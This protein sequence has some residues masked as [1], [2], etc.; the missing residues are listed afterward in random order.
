MKR[1]IKNIVEAYQ[2]LLWLNRILGL[3]VFEVPIGRVWFF[4]SIFY[5]LIRSLAYGF[6]L[7]YAFLLIPPMPLSY[8]SV[9]L[10][11][12]IIV[13]IN[14]VIASVT[15]ILGIYNHKKTK[16]FFKNVSMIDATLECFEIEPV[17]YDDLKENL[18]LVLAWLTGVIIIFT[19][20]LILIYAIF[21]H[22]GHALAV[23]VAFEIPLQINSMI[24]VNFIV[25]IRTIGRR[26]EKLN[27]LIK[28]ITT[29]PSQNDLQHV[30][31]LDLLSPKKTKKN[32]NKIS[33]RSSSYIKNKYDVE[34]ILKMSRQLH[35]NLCTTSREVN[36][37][38]SKQISMQIASS[39]FILTGFGYCIYLVYH[40]PN[41]SL[42][43]KIQLFCSLGAWIVV[44]V[45]RM[46]QVVR[47]TVKVSSEAHKVSQ[48]AHE[49]H[50]TKF[51]SKL[52]DDIHQL[53]LQVMQHPLFFSACGLIVLDFK[54]VR[55]FVGSVTTYWMIL[56]QNQP[57][58]IRA[59]NVLVSSI[60]DN[61]TLSTT[62]P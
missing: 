53:S 1:E 21:D 61:S 12:R 2:P 59:A 48:I 5:A 19:C 51:Q 35:L 11:F 28:N 29:H 13:Y 15:T 24:E 50:V 41:V 25:Y 33:V 54:Y 14:V 32:K 34:I 6:L 40:L 52:V 26:F 4:F 47:T 8:H 62:A 42:P 23:V 36:Q 7:W 57:D 31:S 49:I 17:Y 27:E 20:D 10:M 45:W 30:K 3:A 60:D 46:L 58:M 22:L 16:K 44:I 43:R 55:G 37:T 9:M 56:I 18:R 39:F 38:L